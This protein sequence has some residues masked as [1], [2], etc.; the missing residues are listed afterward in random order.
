[1][2]EEY[3]SDNVE[4]DENISDYIYFEQMDSNESFS[5]MEGFAENVGKLDFREQ[6]VSALN[7]SNPFRN[8]KNKIDNSG[9]YREEWFAYKNSCY[10]QFV[11]DQVPSDGTE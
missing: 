11:K 1:M 8:F 5:A 6:L 7:R 3:E 2:M 9:K 10:I 4:I